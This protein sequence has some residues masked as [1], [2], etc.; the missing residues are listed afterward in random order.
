MVIGMEKPVGRRN[1]MFSFSSTFVAFLGHILEK[2]ML[3]QSNNYKAFFFPSP[4]LL[5]I[6]II[7]L[8]CGLP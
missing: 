4:S 8:Y 3:D 1:A 5:L 6:L 7:R 2:E